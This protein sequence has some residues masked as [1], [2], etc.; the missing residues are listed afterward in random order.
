MTAKRKHAA[1]PVTPRAAAPAERWQHGVEA[2][3]TE[4]RQQIVR[5]VTLLHRSGRV[6]D[7]EV[8]AASRY[9]DDYSFGVCGAADEGRG[10]SGGGVDG[11]NI[12]AIEALGAYLDVGRTLGRDV[13]TTLRLHVICEFS[14]RA[15]V[16]GG[17]RAREKQAAK[18]T[19]ALKALA[20]HY[21]NTD[22]ARPAKKPLADRRNALDKLVAEAQ[23]RGAYE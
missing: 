19:A 6:G 1:A 13:A 22:G 14:V 15:L 12:A 5:P 3:V 7:A 16:G 18:F 10:G 20:D 2:V 11:Y 4:G 23:A 17:A 9:Y 21:S 8:L